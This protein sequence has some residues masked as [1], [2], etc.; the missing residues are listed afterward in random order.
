MPV[1]PP[2]PRSPLRRRHFFRAGR[3]SAGRAGWL[4]RFLGLCLT[5][6]SCPQ[7]F[8]G[9]TANEVVVAVNGSSFNSR[10]LA[11]H[12]VALRKIPA[13]NVVVLEDVPSSEV[14]SVEVFRTKILRPLLDEINRRKLSRHIQCIAY[15]ADFPTAIDISTDLAA[16]ENL[17]A[18]FTKKASIN[19]LTFLYG[20]VL[21]ANPSYIDLRGNYY[22]RGSIDDYF[23]NPGGDSTFQDWKSIEEDMKA[24]KH[25]EAADKLE[26]MLN[27]QPHQFPLA[28]L[29]A[30][31]RALAGQSQESI[32]LLQK[33]VNTGWNAGGYLARDKRFDSL[34]DETDFQVI[35][36]S[37]DEGIV[38]RQPSVAFDSRTAWT[39]NGI[40]VNRPEFGIRFLLSTVLGVTRGNGTSLSE[41]MDALTQSASADFTHPK[42]GF[43]FSVTQDVRSETRKWGFLSAVD[44]LKKLGFEASI[45][46]STLP[47]RQPRVLGVQTGTAS[48]NWAQSGSEFVPGAIADNLTSFGGIMTPGASQTKMTEFLRAGAA[49]S[50]GTVVEPYAI[51]E[52]FPS[53][54]LY[55]HYARGASLAEAFYMSVSGPYQLLIIG[56]PLCRPFS[57]APQVDL[58]TQLRRLDPDASPDFDIPPTGQRFADWS[59]EKEPLASRKSTL[60][61]DIVTAFFDGA[62]PQASRMRPQIRMNLA[63]QPAGYHE[64]SLQFTA[65]DPLRQKSQLTIPV[66]IGDQDLISLQIE[67]GESRTHQADDRVFTILSLQ[68]EKVRVVVRA[69]G[70]E[71]VSLLNQFETIDQAEGETAEF[72]VQLSSLGRGPVRLQAQADFAS[73]PSIRSLPAW[74]RIDP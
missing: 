60:A 64:I 48:F 19:A 44:E 20:P 6:V 4:P 17:N 50:S 67:G 56:D 47:Q 35:E 8:A 46:T 37:L 16:I 32:Q 38:D 36:F 51:A 1:T 11:N 39:P 41:A 45:I 24:G 9:L 14:I 74:L 25:Q 43:Y 70:A 7:L 15:S 2:L 72:E 57:H 55:V 12:Y 13:I 27:R 30:A 5:L 71:R 49:G 62:G 58:E 34:R 61:A 52:K 31:E 59:L 23:R 63:G 69:E 40:P 18:V 21:Q 42:G 28:Y 65:D 68:Q 66:W 29:A 26:A 73:Q 53:S 10:T 3:S 54:D 22:A 33:A